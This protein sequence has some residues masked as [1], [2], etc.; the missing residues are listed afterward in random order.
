M[1][2]DDQWNEQPNVFPCRAPPALL[3]PQFLL[4]FLRGCG[5]SL[6]KTKKG[7]DFYFSVKSSLPNWFS[8]WDP[9]QVP[10]WSPPD[11]PSPS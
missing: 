7:L 11:T 10:G 8:G 4:F 6:E 1:S 9:T 2:L 3:P 5:H